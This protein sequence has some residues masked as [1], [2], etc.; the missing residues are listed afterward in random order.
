[1]KGFPELPQRPPGERG[2]VPSPLEMLHDRRAMVDAGLGPL[3]FVV[4][5]A[6]VDLKAAAVVA[7]AIS[8]VLAAER[9]ARRRSVTNAIGGLIATGV[10]AFI[11]LRTG[12]AET[13]FVP[14]AIY[15]A[16]LALVF[17]G[18]VLVRRP[19]CGF[20]VQALYR[21]PAAWVRHPAVLRAMS[22]LTAAWAALFGVRAILMFLLIAAGQVGWLAAVTIVIGWPAFLALLWASYRYAPRRLA[23]LGAPEPG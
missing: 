9:L 7:V 4:V 8:L 1:V 19:L 14:R 5:N 22:E 17:A 23:Q 3:A 16:L 21:A 12:R 15:Q 18:S 6:I 20:L 10:A 2:N 13:F 11:A